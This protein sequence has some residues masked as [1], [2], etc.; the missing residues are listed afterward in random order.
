MRIVFLQELID[1]FRGKVFG[2]DS[3]LKKSESIKSIQNLE[4]LAIGSS[5]MEW[6]FI[7]LEREYNLGSASL[8]LYYSYSLYKLYASKSIKNVF[9]TFS[10]F[11]PNDMLI[12]SGLAG[13]C[14]SLKLLHGIDYQD[15]TIAKQKGLYNLEKFYIKEILKR[16]NKLSLPDSYYGE[17]DYLHLKPA[18]DTDKIH[19][20]ALAHYKINQKKSNQ[21]DYCVKF[22]EETKENG[23]NLYFVLPPAHQL[24]KEVLPSSNVIFEQLYKVCDQYSHVQILNLY[25]SKEFKDSDFIDGDHLNYGGAVKMSAI[26]HE[27]IGRNK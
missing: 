20:R 17:A 26:M 12:K 1:I 23:Q 27:A 24:Y 4:T 5:H 6:G 25:D 8:D 21:M 2:L 13:I 14:T 11:S 10:V 18:H 7:P 3:M 15:K 9:V 16:K 19:K 22:L